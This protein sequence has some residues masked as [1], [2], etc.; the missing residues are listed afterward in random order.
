MRINTWRPRCYSQGCLIKARHTYE[1]ALAPGRPVEPFR[2]KTI[3]MTLYN[4]IYDVVKRI[5][6][7]NVTSYGKI[8]RMVGC[9]A[10]Q[11][12]YAMAATPADD[13]I[14]WHRVIN[15]KGEISERREGDGACY[16]RTLLMDEGIGFDKNDRIDFER[17]GWIEAEFP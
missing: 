17:F 15:S 3:P 14:P 11:V 7:G 5:P 6:A 1:S 8:A 2:N 13:D 10:R 9:S 4:K 16:Q 12:G